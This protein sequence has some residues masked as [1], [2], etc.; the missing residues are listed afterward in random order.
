MKGDFD[1]DV[2]VAGL[3]DV[4]AKLVYVALLMSAVALGCAAPAASSM[5]I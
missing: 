1:F 5:L 2:I 4:L 3:L